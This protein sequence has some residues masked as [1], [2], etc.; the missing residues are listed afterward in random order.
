MVV[1]ER[2]VEEKSNESI[3]HYQSIG[4]LP[5]H[6]VEGFEEISWLMRLQDPTCVNHRVD[7]YVLCVL[8]VR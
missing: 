6:F 7:H 8:S 5:I 1:M 2:S 4:T 3:L